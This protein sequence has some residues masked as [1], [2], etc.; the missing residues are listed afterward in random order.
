MKIAIIEDD[1]NISNLI[2]IVLSELGLPC[3]QFHNGWVGHDA[4]LS[5]EYTLLVLDVH[6]PGLNGWEICKKVRAFKPKM[7]II[8]LT[9]NSED[10]DKVNGLELGADDYLTKPFNN[11]EL[12]AR[13]KAL[14]RR[15][16]LGMT[17]KEKSKELI[18]IG[19]LV[20]DLTE[21]TLYRAG[22]EIPLTTK[23]F[24]ILHLLMSQAGRNFSR[25]D[26]LERVWGDNFEGLE[27]TVNSNINRLRMKIEQDPPNPKYLLTLWGKGY[28]FVKQIDA[29]K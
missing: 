3:D 20:L 11:R 12:L 4:V 7:P 14:L 19:E 27:H 22:Q 16:E 26:I 28:K 5:H 29:H 25:Q 10:E 13:V 2:S 18:R 8:M 21:N 17:A 24:E 15:A 23:E 1:H 9:S 6:L